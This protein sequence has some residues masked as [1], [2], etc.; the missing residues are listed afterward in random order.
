MN[1]Y[2]HVPFCKHKCS[3]CH[4][5]SVATN[6]IH[7]YVEA[8]LQDIDANLPQQPIETIY[9]GGGT[10]TR[11]ND[12]QISQII[13]HIKNKSTTQIQETTLEAHPD[14]LLDHKPDVFL[15]TGI[16]RLSI[17]IQSWQP[18]ILE[19]MNR[20]YDK[21]KL[22][23]Y[24]KTLEESG[25]TNINLDH[26]IAYPQL[27]DELLADD[28]SQSLSLNPTHISIYPLEI[29][30]H[31]QLGNQHIQT[32]E[33][34]IIRQFSLIQTTLVNHNYRHYEELN[35][36][37]AGHE[38][39]HNLHFWQGKDYLGFG[40]GAVSRVGNSIIEN[41]PSVDEYI[42]SINKHQRALRK[43]TTLTTEQLKMM[44]KDLNN[45]LY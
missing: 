12:D 42:Q 1:V 4:F 3:Y 36:A 16:T 22:I 28:I 43:E 38:C 35:F 13:G 8:L 10:P 5:Y 40:P 7:D 14:S 29:H 18:T 32:D 24:I 15:H 23:E 37:K 30:P 2:I 26:I 34:D 20:A 33:Q 19:H 27:T 39:L 45:R 9:F 17:G 25:F 44:K 31:T 6:Q 21:N 41:E 11:L